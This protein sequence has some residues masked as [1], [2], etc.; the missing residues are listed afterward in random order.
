MKKNK[1]LVRRVPVSEI[2]D[3]LLMFEENNIKYV[4]LVCKISS[5][6]NADG[7]CIKKHKKNTPDEE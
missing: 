7:I 1:V 5:V 4:D 3:V 2:I 6:D